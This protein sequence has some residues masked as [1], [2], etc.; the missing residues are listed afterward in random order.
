MKCQRGDIVLVNYPFSEGQG[1]KIRP[2][3][4]VQCDTNNRRL[5]STLIV[6]IT[7][8]IQLARKVPTQ[9]LVEVA[10]PAG[11]QSGLVNDSAVACENIYTVRQTAIIRVIGSLPEDTMDKVGD[12]LKASLGI[13]HG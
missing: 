5:D 8:R 7:S 10:S 3:L 6:Q 13:D 11:R 4:V 9:L 12:C 2:A 1:A